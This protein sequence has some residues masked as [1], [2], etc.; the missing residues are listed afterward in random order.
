[1]PARPTQSTALGVTMGCA[2]CHDHMFD[3]ISQKEYY[4]LRAVFEPHQVRTDR[5]PGELDASRDGVVRVYDALPAPTWFFIRGDERHP[6]TNAPIATGGLI[7]LGTVPGGRSAVNLPIPA[8]ANLSE[9]TKVDVSIEPLDGNP[10]HSAESVLR[11]DL[12]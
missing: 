3:P 6:L 11:G 8:S 5:R 9:F 1:M 2:K 10:K 7:A 12:V 4:A